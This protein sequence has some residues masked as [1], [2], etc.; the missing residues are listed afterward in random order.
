MVAAGSVEAAAVAEVFAV[1]KL[2]SQE[3]QRLEA[4]RYVVIADRGLKIAELFLSGASDVHGYGSLDWGCVGEVVGIDGEGGD[5]VEA[6]FEGAAN[7]ASIFRLR[8]RWVSLD[9][10]VEFVVAKAADKRV[11]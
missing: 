8:S 1:D 4:G 9:C 6:V 7:L 5:G 2:T 10:A 11:R 3:H